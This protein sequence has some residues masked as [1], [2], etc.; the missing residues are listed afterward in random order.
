MSKQK[1]LMHE[2]FESL[3]PGPI[4][5]AV[6]GAFREMHAQP[7]SPDD[8]MG[9]WSR[10]V[11]GWSLPVDKM[12]ELVQTSEGPRIES[13]LTATVCD[14]ASLTKGDPD[15]R[16]VVVESTFTLLPLGEGWGGPA[17]VVFRFLDSQR[18]YAAVVDADGF[19]KILMRVESSW[20]ALAWAA[21]EIEPGQEVKV[22]VEASGPRLKATFRRSGG[23]ASS[24]REIL[25]EAANGAYPRG[26]VGFIGA[27][28]ARFGPIKVVALPG[29]VERLDADKED[30]RSRLAAKRS[31]YGKPVVWRK[32]PTE[33]FGSGRRIRLGDLTGDGRVDFLLL[34]VN[35]WGQRGLGCMTAMSADG[36]IL[37]QLGQP[38][39]RPQREASADTP[40][41]IHDVDGDGRNEVVC[42]WDEQLCALDGATGKVKY[43]AP[44]PPMQPYPKVFKENMLDW[45]AGFSDE[46]PTVVPSAICFADLAGRGTPRDVLYVDHYHMLVAMTPEFEELWRD[47]TS[48]GHF[49]QAF[50]F[51]GDGREDVLAGYHRLSPD[52]ELLGRV[53]LQDHQDA[54]YVGP[55]DADGKG[56]VKI[57]MAAGEDGLLTLTPGYGI[58]QRVMGHVQRLAVGRFRGDLPGLCV[59][60]VLYH[61][62]PGI[63]SLFDSTLKKLWTRDYPVVGATLQPVNWDG[64]GVEL[65]L[66]SGIRPAQGTPGGLMDGDGEL[67]VP[68]PDDGG[69]GFCA[70]AHDFD[71]DGLDELMLWDYDR[72]WIY[73]TDAEPPAGPRYRPVRPPLWNMSNF[74]SYWSRPRWES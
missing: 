10:R 68:L 58:H 17:G 32:Y 44:L 40:T 15:W 24:S 29:E 52:G 2:K 12:Y 7:A 56:P 46:G 74:Q 66:F 54:I 33:G 39:G 55:L 50:D 8:N 71:G 62:N 59:A 22:R 5:E 28:P 20:D 14:N 73:H 53:C 30:T 18:Y 63:I 35:S 70:L 64:S 19:A 42:V 9:G 25:L 51:D 34:Q 3:R 27:R 49:P 21:A 61:G 60:T 45:G 31:A 72:I 16:D 57:L 26:C 48:H 36:E 47:V 67:V 11:G 4:V 65:M 6:D 43:S 69:P 23:A 41:Q 13:K 1:V 37:W 38:S